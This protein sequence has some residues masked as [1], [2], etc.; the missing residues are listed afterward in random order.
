MLGPDLIVDSTVVGTD[1]SRT[2]I[3]PGE[4]PHA[5]Y[6]RAKLRI[7]LRRYL[8]AMEQTKHVIDA[9]EQ[10]KENP[11]R[12]RDRLTNLLFG[13][14]DSRVTVAIAKERMYARA[15]QVYAAAYH[16]ELAAAGGRE[17]P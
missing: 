7:A 6:L 3:A 17:Q 16:V 13:E 11:S 4:T 8:V 5:H 10:M 14:S 15:V 2:E 9:Y 1:L 12:R